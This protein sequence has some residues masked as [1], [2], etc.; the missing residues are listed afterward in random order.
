M[1]TTDLRKHI[2]DQGL[3]ALRRAETEGQYADPDLQL[4]AYTT[5]TATLAVTSTRLYDALSRRHPELAHRL[6][7][8][9]LD[10]Q[11]EPDEVAAYL[12][13]QAT[14]AGLKDQDAPADPLAA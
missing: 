9:I 1:S 3:A 8:E 7:D 5:M 12:H 10:L 14:A 2:L 4:L 13:A 11:N 6:A